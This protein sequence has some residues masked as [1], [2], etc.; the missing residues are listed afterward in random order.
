MNEIN[1]YNHT[2]QYA[3]A[4]GWEYITP[5]YALAIR[6]SDKFTYLYPILENQLIK[7][8]PDVV[9]T[10]RAKE[11]IRQ[12]DLLKPTIEGN[13][14]ALSWI[15]G[16]HTIF[17]SE[18][19]RTRNFKLIDFD[20]P[21]RNIFQ[22]TDNW[23]QRGN[24][25]TISVDLVF[26]INGIPVAIIEVKS[27][28]PLGITHGLAQMQLYQDKVP[29][30]FTSTQ[31]IVVGQLSEILYGVTW[32]INPNRFYKWKEE[33]N[34]SYESKIKSFFDINRFVEILKSYIFFESKN[35]KLSKI[36][37][38]QHQIKAVDNTIEWLRHPDNKLGLIFFVQGAGK[39]MT[40]VALATKILLQ[41]VSKLQMPTVLIIV[42]RC[43]VQD[44]VAD[45]INSYKMI[46]FEVAKTCQDLQRLFD[47]NYRGLI[48]CTI[49]KFQDIA[50]NLNTREDIFIIIDEVQRSFDKALGNCLM[51]ALPNAIYIGFTSTPFEKD[52]LKTFGKNNMQNY[53]Y[54][55]SLK[56]SIEDGI[57]LPINFETVILDLPEDEIFIN[58]K[59]SDSLQEISVNKE[60][61]KT[62]SKNSYIANK[63]KS[64]SRV[65]KVSAYL[66]QHFQEQVLPKRLKAVL[67][68]VDREACII[69]KKA[70]DKYLP[71]EYSQAI[72][73]R[74]PN[75]VGLLQEYSLSIGQEREMY[76]NFKNQGKA[77]HI[78]VISDKIITG[79][80]TSILGCLYIN[81]PLRGHALF[82]TLCQVSRLDKDNKVSE[83]SFGLVVDF[84]GVYKELEEVLANKKQ[85]RVEELAKE[86]IKIEAER[87][88][89]GLD[90]N[91]FGIYN[92]LESIITDLTIEQTKEINN[93]FTKFP[94]FLDNQ[95]QNKHLRIL[96]Y[97]ALQSFVSPQ[98]MVQIVNDLMKL[99]RV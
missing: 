9:N 37:L 2:L 77:P 45:I 97:K 10:I 27:Y 69:Y 22:V 98:Q 13:R 17:V 49:Q 79:Y 66:A 6:G 29:E 99:N 16:E 24:T 70:L 67:I 93:I 41:K 95:Q 91:S 54:E 26:L 18:Q 86:D 81:K 59:N 96:L 12:F 36:L 92:V 90:K 20:N 47:W 50:V 32:N 4:A 23:R 3:Q 7:L 25:D 5:E 44:Q 35:N 72:Y 76:Q 73:S 78:L 58:N 64:S 62:I 87:Q 89:S 21:S 15:R 38:R 53:I 34:D 61:R 30:L 56:Q 52:I 1:I 85:A 11:I 60:D 42:D 63:L 57:T 19:K 51:S 55:Y 31:M 80:D 33:A 8:N 83:K 43:M 46:P 71:S 84:I 28:H 48:I 94:N 74:N 82:Q 65:E 68:V 75:D 40:I 39:Y 14:D 88:L